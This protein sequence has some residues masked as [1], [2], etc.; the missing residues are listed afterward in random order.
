MG[1]KSFF[2]KIGQ[3]FKKAGRW[4][5]DKALPVVGRIA[6]PILNVVGMLP[7]KIGAIGKVGSAITEVL[8]NVTQKIPNKDAR[9]KINNV[10][11][12]GSSTFQNV[13]DKGKGYAETAN[14]VIDT[15]QQMIG[16]A[17][18]GFKNILKPAI[19]AVRL[20]PI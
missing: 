20:N 4:I 5:K 17:K 6:K 13:V 9:D 19:P 3:G 2:K 12:K 1:L 11:D 10:I 14:K 18:D 16:A 15:G 8:H 7:G